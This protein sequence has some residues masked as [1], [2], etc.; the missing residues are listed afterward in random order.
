MKIGLISCCSTKLSTKN[1]VE[2]QKLYISPL[3]TYALDYC[4]KNYDKNFI[5][6]AKYGLLKLDDL[7][8]NYDFTLNDL[9][10]EHKKYWDFHVFKQS[11]GLISKSDVIYYHCGIKYREGLLKSLGKKYHIPLSNL[12]IGK[13]LQYYKQKKFLK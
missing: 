6:S 13:Q 7:I 2:A 8:E 4:K 10:K 12:G 11:K 1:K 9:S 3:F 5:L